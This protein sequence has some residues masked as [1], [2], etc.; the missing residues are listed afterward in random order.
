MKNIFVALM[1]LVA[2]PITN[3]ILI[4]VKTP[5]PEKVTIT[6]TIKTNSFE[7]NL[8]MLD[9]EDSNVFAAFN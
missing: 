7:E 8:E 5:K 6:T 3:A 9:F 1:V 2:L 4:E